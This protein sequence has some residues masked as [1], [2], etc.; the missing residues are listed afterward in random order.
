M[1]N[2]TIGFG[3]IKPYTNS[4]AKDRNSARAS[5]EALRFSAFF[6]EE[7]KTCGVWEKECTALEKARLQLIIRKCEIEKGEM[8][9]C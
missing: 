6:H 5:V 9:K 3:S 7:V 8:K 1:C 2:S 4:P